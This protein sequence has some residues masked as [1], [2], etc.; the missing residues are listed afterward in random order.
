MKDITR[1]LKPAIERDK[2]LPSLQIADGIS[3]RI[4][5]TVISDRRLKTMASETMS[6]FFYGYCTKVYGS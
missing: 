1:Y 6:L 5:C 4:I 3:I 2:E